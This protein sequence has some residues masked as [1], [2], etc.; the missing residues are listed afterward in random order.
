MTTIE[1]GKLQSTA[2]G[3]LAR[4]VP[5]SC[6]DLDCD[7]MLRIALKSAPYNKRRLVGSGL[8]IVIGIAFLAGTFVFTDTIKRTFDTN[9]DRLLRRWN[10]DDHR[11]GR[12]PVVSRLQDR[13]GRGYA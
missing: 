7:A 8:S 3:H 11:G 12:L 4:L 5:I 9:R 10:T 1:A 2:L 13:A 6:P